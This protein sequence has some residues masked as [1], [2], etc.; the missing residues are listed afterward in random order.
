M[1]SAVFVDEGLIVVVTAARMIQPGLLRQTLAARLSVEKY[2][3][4]ASI[5]VGF[6]IEL[7]DAFRVFDTALWL[8]GD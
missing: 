7:N 5:A 1:T 3:R 2:R 4:K 8:E 6:A